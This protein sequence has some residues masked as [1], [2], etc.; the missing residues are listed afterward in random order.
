MA[1]VLAVDVSGSVDDHRFKLQREGI[2]AA[3]ESEE[4]AT[5]VS[6]GV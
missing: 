3:L 4:V 5:A 1:L 2:A 6:I